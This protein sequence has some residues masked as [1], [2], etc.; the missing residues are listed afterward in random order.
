MM[1][2][3]IDGVFISVVCVWFW[4]LMG[5]LRSGV[6][7]ELDFLVLRHRKIMNTFLL[8]IDILD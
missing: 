1:T 6:F 5:Y 7:L 3:G 2:I 4:D 8:H